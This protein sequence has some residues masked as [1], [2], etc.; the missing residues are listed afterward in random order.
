MPRRIV[1]QI[2]GYGTRR[3]RRHRSL[4]LFLFLLLVLIA[5]QAQPRAQEQPSHGTKSE[6]H[7][8]E[9]WRFTLPQGDPVK[10]RGVF[11]KFECYSCHL[12]I[13]ESFPEPGGD[14]IGPELRQM[15]PVHPLEYFAE[16]I[17]NPG[18]VIGEERYKALD[19]R[20]K[21][22][23][24]NDIMAVEELVDLAAFLKSLGAGHSTPSPDGRGH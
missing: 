14:A 6:M 12:V 17:T 3:R 22:P 10:G 23:S 2:V 15:G 18:A 13:G 20:S 9:D 24:F 1:S 5:W 21:M 19:G 11:V 7:H 16:S 8:P 4:G